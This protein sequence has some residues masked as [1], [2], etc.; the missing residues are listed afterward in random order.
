MIDSL[1]IIP[2]YDEKDNV[3]PIS[4]AVFSLTP[5]TDILFVDDNSP[6]GTGQV[7]DDLIK[8]DKRIYVIHNQKKAGLGRAYVAGFKWAIQRHYEFIFEMDADFSHDPA[9]LPNFIKAAQNADLV[10]GSRYMHGIRITNWPLSR[11]VMS[12][13]AALYVRIVTGLPVTDPTGGFKCYRRRVLTSI[14][15]DSIVSNGYSFQVEMSYT[16]WMKGF[17]IAEI[18]ITFV[19]RRAGYSKMNSAIFKEALWIVWKLAFRHGLRR[20]PQTTAHK[21]S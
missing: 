7:I 9:E 14:D 20:T 8:A 1:V 12:K 13:G 6:D 11:L 4:R 18:P 17:R 19:D 10:L 16:T 2:T 21:E 3:G 15:L 5:A